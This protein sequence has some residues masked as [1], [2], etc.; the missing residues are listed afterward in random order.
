MYLFHI[1]NVKFVAGLYLSEY[2]ALLPLFP[3]I[4]GSILIMNLYKWKY[5]EIVVYPT[6]FLRFVYN[7]WRFKTDTITNGL[8]NFT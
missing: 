3:T 8:E 6:S 1:H 7:K 4:F 5:C 2:Q